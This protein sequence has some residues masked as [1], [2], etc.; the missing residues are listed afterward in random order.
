[1]RLKPSYGWC[2]ITRSVISALGWRYAIRGQFLQA[3]AGEGNAVFEFVLFAHSVTSC[4]RSINSDH[5]TA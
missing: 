2:I 5:D 3:G 1:M 4:A